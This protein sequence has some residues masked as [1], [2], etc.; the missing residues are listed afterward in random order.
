[1]MA[2]AMASRAYSDLRFPSLAKD[3]ATVVREID[4]NQLT[5]VVS[6][7]VEFP[8]PTLTVEFVFSQ[9]DDRPRVS[10]AA[11]YE[12]RRACQWCL[13]PKAVAV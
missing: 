10:V 5:R 2:A 7:G 11:G 4:T 1:M 3:G 12:V 13:E 9:I 8:A 6:L